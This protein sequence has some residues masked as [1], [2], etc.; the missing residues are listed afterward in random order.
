MLSPPKEFRYLTRVGDHGAQRSAEEAVE[1]AYNRNDLAYREVVRNE[2]DQKFLV[3]ESRGEFLAW[4]AEL[5]EKRRCLHEVIFGWRPQR[6]KFDVDIMVS[7]LDAL[8]DSILDAAVAAAAAA[9]DDDAAVAAAADD[10]AAAA[11]DSAAADE[12]L[13]ALLAETGAAAVAAATPSPEAARASKARAIVSLLIEAILD[14]LYAAYMGIEDISAARESLVVTDSSGGEKYSYH[15]LVLPFYVADHMEAKEF[16]AKVLDRLPPLVQKFVDPRVNNRT[17]NFRLAGSAKP[18]TGRYKHATAAAAEAFGTAKGVPIDDLFVSAPPGARVLAR[19]Y[20]LE[21]EAV[22]R[23]RIRGAALEAAAGAVSQAVLALAAKA[24]VTAGHRFTEMRGHLLCFVREAPSH[25]RICGE[26]H[27]RDN[28]LML[29]LEPVEGGHAGPWPGTGR[30]AYRVVE[31][32]RQARG[33]AHTVG[34]VT[35]AAEDLRALGP[36]TWRPSATAAAAVAATTTARDRLA[37]HVTA[38]RELRVNPHNALASAFEQLPPRQKTVYAEGAM[39]PYEL[40]PTLAVLAQMKLGKTKALRAYLSAHFPPD[41]LETHVIRF[42]TFRQTFSNAIAR[43]FPGFALYSDAAGDLDP[44]RYPRLIVQ[45]ESL[46][47]LTIGAR[48]E[49]VDL[50]ILDEVESILAQFNSGLHKQFNAAFAVFQWMM[51]TARFVVCMD[52]NLSDRTYRTLE[53]LR[54]GRPPHF[55]W[56]RF[57]RAAD[58]AYF[59]TA[60]QGAWLGRLYGAIRAGQRVVIPTNSLAEGR[61][62]EEAIRREFPDREVMMYSSETSPSEKTRHFSDVHTFWGKLDVLIFTPTCSAGVSFELEHFDALFGYFCDVSCDVETCRQMLGRVRNL[63]TRE[64][65][66]C[67]RAT[68]ANLPATVEDI[69]RGI[70]DRRRGLYRSIDDAALQFDYSAD[71]E[72][73]FYESNYYYLWLETVRITNLSRNDFARR[74]IDQ[75]ADTG[76]RIDVL[77]VAEPEAGAAL[78]AA[79]RAVRGELRA[80]RDEAVAAAEDLTPDAAAAV[81]DALTAGAGAGADIAP[82]V[83]LAYEKYQLREAYSWHDRPLSAQFVAA[84]AGRDA[85]RVYRNL[86]RISGAGSMREAIAQI[87]AQEADHYEYVMDTRAPG[88]EYISE[89]RDLLREK[90]SYVFRS[91]F[92][93]FWFLQMC[94]FACITDPGRVHE[95]LLEGR[96]RNSLPLLRRSSEEIIFEFEVPRPGFDRLA[97]EPDR[98]RFLAG[99]LRTINAVLRKMYGVQLQRVAKRATTGVGTYFLGRSEV[100]KL[101]VF[102]DEP[103]PDD[104]PGGPRPH[105]VSA[106]RT[107]QQTDGAVAGFLEEEWYAALVPATGTAAATDGAAAAQAPAA[108]APAPTAAAPAPAAAA[109]AEDGVTEAALASILTDVVATDVAAT[110]V[111]ATEAALAEAALA[112][113]LADVAATDVAA[114]DEVAS[115]LEDEW[116]TTTGGSAMA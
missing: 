55:H 13:S 68:G 114:T 109:P 62:F 32:C 79:H 60:D 74:F 99:M 51:A 116:R 58:D 12:Y 42:V 24:G 5:P 48:P 33:K 94:G 81:R 18:N 91:H 104:T 86:R 69:S 22:A 56:N 64:H 14:E 83:R 113:I 61:A 100:G 16:T 44:I 43:D 75:V 112:S 27:H 20:T 8:P 70:R 40:T 2:L 46:H 73:R 52:A 87:R 78:L 34:E 85:R 90:T 106:L 102:A 88:A 31:Y 95:C 7:K 26:V 66:I 77:A 59:F 9:A 23:P 89:S 97:R 93:A 111:A 92:I 49:P 1:A 57:Q 4:Y 101:F 115:F 103:E 17:Q 3:F 110:D 15:I 65:Y 25:C 29:S 45:V 37:A 82:E 41:S 11:A 28:S 6:L 19:V 10:A 108:A 21:P 105:I 107:I 53:R 80:G 39:R 36:A 98:A 63:R 96:L 54:P 35:L 71:G 47:R 72:I 30:A 76:A 50:L 38:I 84:Y 67:L